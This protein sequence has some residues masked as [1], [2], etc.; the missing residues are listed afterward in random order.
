MRR[1]NHEVKAG[2]GIK[3][4]GEHLYGVLRFRWREDGKKGA[5]S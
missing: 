1:F 5:R 3:R 4:E 2:L